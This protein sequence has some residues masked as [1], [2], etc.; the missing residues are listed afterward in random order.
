MEQSLAFIKPEFIG[1]TVEII[2][3]FDSF[4]SKRVKFQRSFPLVIIPSEEL[5]SQHYSGIRE[6][7]PDIFGYTVREFSR[8]LLAV[9]VYRG[10]SGMI[11]EGRYI[12]GPTDPK[13]AEQWQVRGRFC[14]DSMEVSLSEGRA[15]KNAMHFSGTAEEGE[16]EVARFLPLFHNKI[17]YG[18]YSIR[19][20]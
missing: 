15:V 2:D 10:D 20:A 3:Y 19:G 1:Q 12:L 18:R 11:K 5:I 14:N 7:F 17:F 13:K 6:R 8:G 4:L 9:C 16:V